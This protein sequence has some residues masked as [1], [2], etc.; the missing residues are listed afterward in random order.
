MKHNSLF[1][2][3]L[4]HYPQKERKC[5]QQFNLRHCVGLSLSHHLNKSL[6]CYISYKICRSQTLEFEER[7]LG[8]LLPVAR[9]VLR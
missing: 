2:S 3:N 6:R 1:E 9:L 8:D 4:F 7:S 5:Q